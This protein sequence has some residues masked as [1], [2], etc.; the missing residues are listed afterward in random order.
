MS[1]LAVRLVHYFTHLGTPAKRRPIAGSVLVVSLH[2]RARQSRITITLYFFFFV[3]TLSFFLKLFSSFVRN[4]T[5]ILSRWKSIWL[6][7]VQNF[8]N[9]MFRYSLNTFR[10]YAVQTQGFSTSSSARDLLIS[11]A[12]LCST[13]PTA[14]TVTTPTTY[15]SNSL[16]RLHAFFQIRKRSYFSQASRFL[17]YVSFF[18]PSKLKQTISDKFRY[19]ILFYLPLFG[20][21]RLNYSQLH[22][23]ITLIMWRLFLLEIGTLNTSKLFTPLLLLYFR[24]KHFSHQ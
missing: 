5:I 20:S 15:K 16:H 11:C 24:L 3:I 21:S 18:L 7:K 9:L 6:M 8:P 14:V 10:K 22:L 4:S 1:W 17:S 13:L 23:Q 12:I 2:V 19:S